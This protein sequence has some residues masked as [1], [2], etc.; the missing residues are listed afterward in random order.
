MAV[1]K[2]ALVEVI[3]DLAS[4]D[5]FRQACEVCQGKTWY[6][7]NRSN[8]EHDIPFWKMDLDGVAAFDEIWQAAQPACEALAGCKLR[9]I[10]QYANGHTYGLG[11]Q[12]HLDD[13]RPETFTL[14][15]YPMVEWPSS[16]Q[17]E[18]V[19]HDQSGEI[20]IAVTP[21]PNRAVFFDAR[22][23]H[24]GR[25]PS[26]NC[27]ALRVTVAYKLEAVPDDAA[28]VVKSTP[29]ATKP[30]ATTAEPPAA[31]YRLKETERDGARRTY[32]IFTPAAQVTDLVNQRLLKMGDTVRLPGY[33]P[34]KIP[35]DVLAA[36]YG[37]KARQEVLQR[38][39][40]KAAAEVLA[41]GG[42]AAAL[43]ISHGLESGDVSFRLVAT[44][45]ADLPEPRVTEWFLEKLTIGDPASLPQ[46]M[47]A[48]EA[49]GYLTQHLHKQALDHLHDAFVF[50]LARP[51]IEGELAKILQAISLPNDTEERDAL[52]LR[53]ENI[54]ERRVRLGAILTELAR[55]HQLVTQK[56]DIALER[57]V[58][59]WLIAHTKV[60]E[61]AATTTDWRDILDE[62]F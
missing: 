33:R 46:E 56:N 49:S 21:K 35:L 7:G 28:P 48:E 10:R 3:E 38:I 12:P 23:P 53:L 26:R 29:A 18:T 47:G 8:D 20:A 5:L 57:R 31:P 4:T 34:G 45:L 62:T 36:R 13:L 42:L 52:L 17:G 44:H 55:R 14:L 50:P 6:F 39:A 61:R 15:Y 32:E 19:F 54:A 25:A 59:D 27:P 11:G 24:A 40:E 22:I 30:A 41:K 9:V 43:D 58:I 16:W 1:E 2:E 37:T 60:N 51:L